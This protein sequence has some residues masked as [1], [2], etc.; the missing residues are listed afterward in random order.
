MK[1]SE[2]NRAIDEAIALAREA[3]FALPPFALWGPEEWRDRREH[4]APTMARGLGWD[5]TDFGRGDFAAFGLTLLTMRNGSLRERDAGVGQT[6]AEKLMYQREGQ[7]CPFHLHEI[8]TEDIINRGRGTIQA[9]LY[10]VDWASGTA[11]LGSGVTRT[12]VSGI[13]RDVVAGEPVELGPGEWIQ[14]PLGCYHRFTAQHGPVLA[15]EVSCVNDDEGD[16]TFLVQASRFPTIEEDE[17][18]RHLTTAEYGP[19][20]ADLTPQPSAAEMAA[21]SDH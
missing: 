15:G 4:L 7:E 19:L 17:P 6:Y 18:A 1:R 12:F 3:G 16:N 21:L 2:I 11:A 5:V 8:K 10:P 9:E 13:L 20:L 14:V